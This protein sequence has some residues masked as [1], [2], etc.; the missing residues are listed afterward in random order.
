MAI[1]LQELEQRIVGVLIEKQMTVP[2]TYPLTMNSLIAGCNQKSNR[3]PRMEVMDWEVEGALRSL[4]DK[5]W[6]VRVEPVVGHAMRYAHQ[7]KEQLGVSP[8]DLAVFAELLCR[9][10]QT[11]TELKTRCARMAYVG[12]PADVTERLHQLADRPSPYV[13]RLPKRPREK[14]QRWCHLLD[15]RSADEA[16]A[17]FSEGASSGAAPAAS[18]P[19]A[20]APSAPAPAAPPAA[21]T[22][23]EPAVDEAML[24][25]VEALERE[26]EDLKERLDRLTH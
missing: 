13:T 23:P 14:M 25:R 7:A 19:A 16:V 18:A 1:D 20:A 5:G 15:G 6:V 11:P 3:D 8:E 21:P 2:D 4:M 10:P 9:G 12:G 17:G 24:A 26:V 22:P